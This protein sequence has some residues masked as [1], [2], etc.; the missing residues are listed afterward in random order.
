MPSSATNQPLLFRDDAHSRHAREPLHVTVTVERRG[1]ARND[2]SPRILVVVTNADLAGAP[3]HVRDLVLSLRRRFSI[4]VAFGEQGPIKDLLALEG[5]ETHL[6]PRLASRISPLADLQTIVSLVALIRSTRAELVHAHSTK[7]GMVARL[8][9]VLARVPVL[10]TIHGWGFG[11]GR[12][13]RQSRFVWLTER[14]LAPIGSRY[15]TVSQADADVARDA[16]GLQPPRMVV[17][18]NG[19]VDDPKRADPASAQGIAMVAR[20]DYSKDYETALSAFSQLRADA[21]FTCIGAG[22]D[23]ED[24]IRAG[25][26]WAG[27]AR[28]RVRF[29]GVTTDVAGHLAAAARPC[30]CWCHATKVCPLSI[31]EA[32]RA[33]L[34]VVATDAGGARADRTRRNRP[35][36]LDRCRGGVARRPAA[37]RR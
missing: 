13:R 35:A 7:A 6:L 33:G 3:S 26:R 19:V 10:F 29:A 23:Q 16:F 36:G 14:V 2:G 32:M 30:S 31:I 34:P 5:I 21:T 24:F 15:V 37:S 1:Q 17:I 12:P 20:V 28:S 27:E 9:G 22:T 8:A 11:I 25:E 4:V 18:H